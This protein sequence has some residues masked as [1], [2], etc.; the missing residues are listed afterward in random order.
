MNK[1]AQLFP[2]PCHEEIKFT[3]MVME[4]QLPNIIIYLLNVLTFLSEPNNI[5]TNIG[6]PSAA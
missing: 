5:S 4:Y 1:G 2:S 3:P 6:I